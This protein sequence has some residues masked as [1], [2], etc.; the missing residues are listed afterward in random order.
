MSKRKR[1]PRDKESGLLPPDFGES[2]QEPP[3]RSFL[4]R[5]FSRKGNEASLR[6]KI[7]EF[8]FQP[9]FSKDV[10]RALRLYFGKKLKGRTL[11]IEEEEMPGFQEWCIHD[12]V[13]SDGQRLIDRFAEE[14][15]PSLPEAEAKL[16]TA[17]RAMNR[18][19][20]FEVQ[21]VQHGTGVVVRD[22]LN[23][24]TLTIND[25][26]ASRSMQRWM[27]VLARP[28]QAEDRICFTGSS[29]A[30]TP[31]WKGEMVQAA[32]KLWDDYRARRS[33]AT[34]SEFYRDRSLDLL[35]AMQRLQEEAMRPPVFLT[36]EGHALVEAHAE[37]IVRDAQAVADIL[38]EAEEFN[39]AGPS[40]ADTRAE[41]FNWLLRG[42]S[43]VPE[44][45]IPDKGAVALRTD[46]TAGPGE[47]SF[48]SLGD[49]TLWKDRL[50]LE[51]M[52]RERLKA[53]KALLAE[54][55]GDLAQHRRDR[56]KPLKLEPQSPADDETPRRR[57]PRLSR[58]EQA[59]AQEMID[60]FAA[61]WLN[62]P[63]PALGNL[64]PRQAANIPEHRDKVIELLKQLEY[65]EDERQARGEPPAM[66]VARIRRDLGLPSSDF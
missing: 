16:L 58:E 66:D 63:I 57:W 17:W 14:V 39:D 31:R 9:R 38:R 5:L 50:E 26:S 35:H 64:S 6:E 47:P 56:V 13:L 44:K 61:E 21:S 33:E 62:N 15:G 41:H 4:G 28:H 30:L 49:L 22:L 51:C 48:R 25:R 59:L 52:S 2:Y 34:P 27:V 29:P 40:E 46:W 18:L 36:A 3:S 11:A 45:P 54:M 20:L 37:Y 55:L 19:R 23:D 32:Q 65:M 12:F 1:P 42:R 60:R 24:E 7:T 10:E 8:V 43:R 53:G